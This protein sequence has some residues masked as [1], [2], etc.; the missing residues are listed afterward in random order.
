[1]KPRELDGPQYEHRKEQ[2]VDKESESLPAQ[3]WIN[4]RETSVDSLDYGEVAVS[5]VNV[6][7]QPG[8]LV[9]GARAIGSLSPSM[10]VNVQNV[11]G[12]K[13]TRPTTTMFQEMIPQAG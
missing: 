2:T 10:R 8:D 12:M 7:N 1:M 5:E 6:W 11:S 3:A 9:Q 13:R 4:G